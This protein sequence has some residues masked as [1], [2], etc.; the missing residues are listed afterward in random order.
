MDSTSKK[1]RMTDGSQPVRAT[2]LQV[3]DGVDN[4]DRLTKQR[5]PWRP[6]VTPFQHI[7]HQDYSGDGS[8]ADP[9][10]V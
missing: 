1:P 5:R 3:A 8:E 2:S 9:F 6:R 10:I 4:P 7:L